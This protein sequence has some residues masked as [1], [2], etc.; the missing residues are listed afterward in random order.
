LLYANF[1]VCTLQF[2]VRIALLLLLATA[3]AII[4]S[5]LVLLFV[6]LFVFLINF[7]HQAVD[8]LLLLLFTGHGH[9]EP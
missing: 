6:L 9:R 5:R 3:A 4:I 7:I 2:I 1:T 8:L